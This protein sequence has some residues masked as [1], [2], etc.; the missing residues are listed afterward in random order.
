MSDLVDFGDFRRTFQV[1]GANFAVFTTDGD[2]EGTAPVLTDQMAIGEQSLAPKGGGDGAAAG[3]A[4][5]GEVL[6]APFIG[7][8]PD[9][10]LGEPLEEV[11]VCPLGEGRIVAQC[12]E[13]GSLSFAIG[14]EVAGVLSH[15]MGDTG[16]AQ[17]HLGDIALAV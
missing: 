13:I 9:G 5:K 12:G 16:I 3:A 2:G 7:Q 11:D 15:R 17:F 1:D 14:P 6:Y 10:V 8:H 4:G